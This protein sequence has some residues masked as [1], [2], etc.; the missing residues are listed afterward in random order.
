M[1]DKPTN[2]P[3]EPALASTAPDELHEL[4]NFIRERGLPVGVAAILGLALAVGLTAYRSHVAASRSQAA[5]KLSTA[6]TVKDLENVV[7][8]HASTPTAPLAM[9]KLAHGYFDSRNYDAAMAKYAEFKQLYPTHPM[10]LA[11]DLGRA[12]C[13][14]AKGQIQEALTEF[15]GFVAGHPKHFLEPEAVF[16]QARCLEALGK[17]DEARAVCEDFIASNPKS[18]WVPH[19]EE[20]VER[21]KRPAEAS[22]AVTSAAALPLVPEAVFGTVTGQ[23]VVAP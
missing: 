16:G 17:R 11:A 5:I 7:T 20:Q 21:L 22:E 18:G 19:A 2:K 10:V 12:H 4:R 6:R 9:L 1:T 15:S 3:P 14:E 8:Q 13:L 23:T